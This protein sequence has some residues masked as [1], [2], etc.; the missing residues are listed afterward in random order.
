MNFKEEITQ[1]QPMYLSSID[2]NFRLL[3]EWNT[4]LYTSTLDSKTD[5]SKINYITLPA[6]GNEPILVCDHFKNIY[7]T[8][9]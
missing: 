3:S 2:K 1:L 9:N 8:M 4:F 6:Y 5:T 7:F